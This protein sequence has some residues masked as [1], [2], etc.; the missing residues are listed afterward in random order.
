MEGC[1]VCVRSA[2]THTMQYLPYLSA[3]QSLLLS[4]GS[5]SEYG[6]F[7]RLHSKSEQK[8]SAGRNESGPRCNVLPVIR[9]VRQDGVPTRKSR[10]FQTIFLPT[11][12]ACATQ[13]TVVVER[14]WH[15]VPVIHLWVVGYRYQPNV[16]TLVACRP[17]WPCSTLNSTF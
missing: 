2:R 12:P 5:W 10:H 13:L 4:I 8:Q 3:V 15:K 1:L 9:L 6:L 7:C 16:V 11:R 17:F 14:M